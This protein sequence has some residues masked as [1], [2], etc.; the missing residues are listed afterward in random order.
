VNFTQGAS[1]TIVDCAFNNLLAAGVNFSVIGAKAQIINSTFNGNLVGVNVNGGVVNL[2]NSHL[3]N[4]S[5]AIAATGPGYTGP[6][7]NATY[8][9]NGT[10]RVRVS[11][12]T[13]FDN[14]TAFY[15][16]NPGNRSNSSCNGSNIFLRYL[17]YGGSTDILG[18]STYVLLAGAYDG[19]CPG[20]PQQ[21]TIDN[22]QPPL[23]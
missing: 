2:E 22:Y 14:S 23:I 4:N 11:G 21:I 19:G 1:L 20:P 3:M 12:G 7:G 9:P 17:Q 8:P 15:M 16:A 18:N 5:V 13:V 10:T 6:S